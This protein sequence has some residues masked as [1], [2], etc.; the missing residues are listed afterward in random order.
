MIKIYRRRRRRYH[1][2]IGPNLGF[3]RRYIRVRIG[4]VRR[5]V[6]GEGWG[7]GQILN[8]KSRFEVRPRQR[9]SFES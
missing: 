9:P 7:L 6:A 1:S 8:P 2:A 5:G 3:G 4:V